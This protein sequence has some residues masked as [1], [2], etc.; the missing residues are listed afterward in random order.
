MKAVKVL[1]LATT[2][3]LI[4]TGTLAPTA[5]ATTSTA[6]DP[7]AL[8]WQDC[9]VNANDIPAPQCA[10][11]Q[12]PV[13]WNNPDGP[14]YG[15]KLARRTATNQSARVG[16]MVFGAGGPGDS[17]VYRI[18]EG[19]DR[20]SDELRSRFDIVSFDPRGAAG[21]NPVV[22]SAALLAKAPSPIITSQAQYD[23]TIKYNRELAADCRENTGPLFEHLDSLQ[24]V[25]D[26]EAIRKA[27]GE[28]K[29]TF[30][31]SS[32]GTMLGA[33]YAEQY[34][35]KVRAVVL[36]STVDH[37]LSTR[38]FL[39][40]QA[41][42]AQDSFDEF[43]KWCDGTTACALHE[44]DVRELWAGLL[45]RAGRGEL[46][47]PRDPKQALTP[48]TLSF[49]ATKFFKGP[50]W[51]QLALTLKA[52]EASKPPVG[53]PN[54]PTG[55]GQNPMLVF[56][57]DWDLPVRSY[58]EYAGH[59][60]R[61]ARIAPDM[62]YPGALI[63]TSTCLGRPAVVDNPQH[64]LDVHTKIPLLVTTA[65][66]DPVSGYNWATSVARQLG[67]HGVLLTYDGWGHG[68]YSSSPCSKALIDSYLISQAVPARGTHCPAVEPVQ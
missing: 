61:L 31:G 30:H 4:A 8:V 67:R 16:A 37:S 48:F 64:R 23:A 47:H 46:A 63:A 33:Q 66:H 26:L 59:L 1:L 29:L 2:V 7:P 44:R 39:D 42:S 45:T 51:S 19:I 41:E 55:L 13:D 58:S 62:K 14:T 24:S 32:Y 38:K 52:L 6:T 57:Q 15:L 56:C 49:L 54:V 9:P 18:R 22:C 25:K 65:V 40:T 11:L 28:G 34:P 53:Q 68:T 50:E 5:H 12:L 60:R 3:G 27:L 10:T 21:S 20:F 35:Q 36:E 17:G 43:V